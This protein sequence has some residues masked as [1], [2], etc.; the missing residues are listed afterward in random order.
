MLGSLP[1]DTTDGFDVQV[2]TL[3]RGIHR[4]VTVQHP[5]QP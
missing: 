4:S 5:P 3:G 1:A 2:K